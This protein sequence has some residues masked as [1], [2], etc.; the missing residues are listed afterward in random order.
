TPR[1]LLVAGASVLLNLVAN[2]AYV[3]ALERAD[4]SLTV[5]LL[6]LTPAMAAAFAV[7]MLG[8]VPS[9]A[10]GLGILFV[11]AGALYLGGER[12]VGAGPA[13]WWR[14]LRSHPAG[15]LMLVV[16][17]C[18]SAVLPLDK[19][20]LELVGA[21]A[22]ALGLSAGVAAGTLLPLL[23]LR[24]RGGARAVG[25]PG[26]RVGLLPRLLAAVLVSAAALGLQLVALQWV[27]VGVVETVKRAVGN[28]LALLMGRLLFSEPVT[29]RKVVALALMAVGVM[30]LVL[31][32]TR[33]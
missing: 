22:H 14:A 6:S 7:P 18:W 30:L 28:L 23:A 29:V 1:Y 19:I 3:A 31:P 2:V 12:A 13:A 21:P 27:L 17:V 15:L 33:G 32:G 8:E 5:P 4:L 24:G 20:A 16:A 10:Q 11:V 26:S 9:P 25:A